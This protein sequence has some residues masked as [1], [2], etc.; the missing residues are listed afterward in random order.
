MEFLEKASIW[1]CQTLGSILGKVE[2]LARRTEVTK[3]EGLTIVNL[4]CRRNRTKCKQKQFSKMQLMR[5]MLWIH[6]CSRSPQAKSSLKMP[7]TM[8]VKWYKTL[9]QKALITPNL[10]ISNRLSLVK[11]LNRLLAPRRIK[12]WWTSMASISKNKSNFST[13]TK[14]S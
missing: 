2:T 11:H 13:T 14:W 5:W 3:K 6:L 10:K 1:T 7:S 8:I 4:K 12:Y 9:Q